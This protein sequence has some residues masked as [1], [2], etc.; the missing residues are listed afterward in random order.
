MCFCMQVY[1]S[2]IFFSNYRVNKNRKRN[3]KVY[4]VSDNRWK[5]KIET[6][7]VNYVSGTCCWKVLGRDNKWQKFKPGMS[8]T[9]NSSYFKKILAYD[10]PC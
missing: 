8:K 1:G 9:P 6:S 7:Y 4:Y 2:L 10:Q 3:I 5:N